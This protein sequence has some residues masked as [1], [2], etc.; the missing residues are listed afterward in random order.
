MAEFIRMYVARF[1]CPGVS[2]HARARPYGLAEA[3]YCLQIVS[4]PRIFGIARYSPALHD[5]GPLEFIE[6]GN[7]R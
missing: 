6:G 4:R 7:S 1:A 3:E 2:L 5:L